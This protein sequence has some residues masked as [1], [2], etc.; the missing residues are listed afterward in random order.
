MN[1]KASVLAVALTA[2]AAYAVDTNDVLLIVD[3]T[4]VDQV[5][6]TATDGVSAADVTGSDGIGVYFED[7]YAGDGA[8][9]LNET[10]V[11]GDLTS[12]GSPSDGT[13]NLFR[14]GTT[15]PGLNLFS[16]TADSDATFT[17][18]SQ[19]FTGSAVWTLESDDFADMAALGNR[20][21][22]LY[23]PADDAGDLAGA[24]FIGLYQVIVPAP[25]ALP[26]LGL[27]LGFAARRRR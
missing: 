1:K 15:D 14:S 17:A 13:P 9:G 11:S 5:T 2:G 27:G 3:L 7:F 8:S 19:A 21:G 25:A 12:V 20:S 26:L 16:W 24:T 22:L 6:I 23:F 18:G 10:L 4:V